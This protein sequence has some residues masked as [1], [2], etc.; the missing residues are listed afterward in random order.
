LRLDYTRKIMKKI[1]S[2]S[3]VALLLIG[4]RAKPA[5]DDVSV[6]SSYYHPYGFSISN[7]EWLSRGQNGKVVSQLKGGAVQTIHYENGQRHGS[8]E[9]TFPYTNLVSNSE[10]YHHGQL[11]KQTS[12]YS[13]GA[14]KHQ[15]YF[16]NS[17]EQ[18]IMTWY[19]D[20]SPQSREK[21]KNKQL[22]E[23]KYIERSGT[24]ESSIDQGSGQRLERDSHFI[25]AQE[26][27]LN[28]WLISRTE[29][30]PNKKISAQIH[31]DKGRVHGTI[32]RY[33]PQGQLIATESWKL[34]KREGNVEEFV[35]GQKMAEIP[36]VNNLKHGQEKRFR[37]EELV[38]TLEW[39]EGKKHGP[40]H[41]FV[42]GKSVKVEYYYFDIPV[43]KVA[44]ENMII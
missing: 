9:W 21:W 24:V 2:L 12:H 18:Q 28:G 43:S 14:P 23:A 13:S 33:N 19:E 27:Y 5:A 17:E 29:F 25:V 35:N 30:F 4:C 41:M 3:L 11:V 38:E 44:F 20:G 15:I 1:V 42:N 31:H 10:E 34:G 39:L 36:F 40:H 7:Q 22:M 8:A 37:E 32:E 6:A 16:L 26:E